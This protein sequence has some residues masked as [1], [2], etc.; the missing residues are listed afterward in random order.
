[1]VA[2]P[3]Q[4]EEFLKLVREKIK[5]FGTVYRPRGVNLE[6]LAELDIIPSLRDDFI[7]KLTFENYYSGPK[8]DTLD[9]N[10]PD[11]Y[12]FGVDIKGVEVY[13]KL[14]LNLPGK[15]VDCMSFHKAVRM[16]TYPLKDK[17]R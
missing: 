12:E 13:V 14:S 15:P 17:K 1:M 10:K 16:I 3:E 9:P 6:A 5:V 2:T 8:N 7:K 11:Y 4:V